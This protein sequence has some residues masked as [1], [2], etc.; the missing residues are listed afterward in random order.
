MKNERKF[1]ATLKSLIRDEG[2]LEEA[3]SFIDAMIEGI[4][5][6]HDER[7]LKAESPTAPIPF[8]GAL[9]VARARI[10][11]SGKYSRWNRLWLDSYSASY[12]TPEAVASY[13]GNRLGYARIID[14]GCGAGMQSIFFADKGQITDI[15]ISP[16]RAAMAALNF[17]VYDRRPRRLINADYASVLENMEISNGDVIFSDPLRPKEEGERTLM[18]L[19][20]SPSVIRGMAS[21]RT[22][23]F[24]FDLPP[25]MQWGNMDLKGEKE[26]IS[27]GGSLNRF[28]LY[29]GPLAGADS[30]AV[31]LPKGVRISGEPADLGLSLASGP[32]EHLFLPDPSLA[33]S[34]LIHLLGQIGDFKALNSDRRRTLLTA[35]EVPG[36]YFPGEVFLKRW[37][38]PETGLSK[39]LKELGGGH[40]LPRFHISPEKYYQFRSKLEEGQVGEKEMHLFRHEGN[41]IIAER[42]EENDLK[43]A[44]GS[45][46]RE[47]S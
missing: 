12:S 3:N 5:S 45:I 41:Y 32:D 26:Y 1:L 30:S 35:H 10:S 25:Q 36:S 47:I 21:G 28:T 43:K 18:S 42:M 34:R 23:S 11:V 8:D 39:A 27:I 17:T 38:G 19:V 31:L 33:Y 9:E 16:L 46:V 6:G 20:P 4:R 7:K 37:T 24:V 15:E 40:V 44:D 13:R 2:R 29:Q 22:E 14:I